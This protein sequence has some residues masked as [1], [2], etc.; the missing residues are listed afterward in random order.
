MRR[1]CLGVAEA[2]LPPSQSPVIAGRPAPMPREQ[3]ILG[4]LVV[5]VSS[6]GDGTSVCKDD[7]AHAHRQVSSMTMKE[8]QPKATRTFDSGESE[9]RG[10]DLQAAGWWLLSQVSCSVPAFHSC[11]DEL[12]LTCQRGVG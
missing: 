11:D 4:L 12:R 7:H 9:A 1:R 10:A 8:A 2:G 3:F 5:Q 6:F